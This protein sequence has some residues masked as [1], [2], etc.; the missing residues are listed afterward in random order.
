MEGI[1]E[2]AAE[3]CGLEQCRYDRFMWTRNQ[4]LEGRYLAD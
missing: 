3:R 1:E 4:A 2:V